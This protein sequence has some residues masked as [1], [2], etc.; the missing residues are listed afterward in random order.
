VT[1]EKAVVEKVAES[2]AHVLAAALEARERK[3]TGGSR[4]QVSDEGGDGCGLE[5]EVE[6][7][8]P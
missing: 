8:S 3:K 2:G 1:G 7:E 5:T 4:W 6:G